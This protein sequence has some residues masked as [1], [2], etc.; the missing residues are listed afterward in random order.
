MN[1]YLTKIM[2]FHDELADLKAEFDAS[3]GTPSAAMLSCISSGLCG[4]TLKPSLVHTLTQMP[5]PLRKLQKL[6]DTV[7][8]AETTQEPYLDATILPTI[9]EHSKFPGLRG[10]R[11]KTPR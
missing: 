9:S 4:A 7:R 2:S 11:W 8:Q 3:T 1:K 5:L 10:Q 6:T